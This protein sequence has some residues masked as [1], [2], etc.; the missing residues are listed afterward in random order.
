MAEGV[1]QDPDEPMDPP[2]EHTGPE[3]L[4]GPS[5]TEACRH[6]RLLDGSQVKACN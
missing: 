1:K 5:H 6:P 3:G 4:R 2:Q